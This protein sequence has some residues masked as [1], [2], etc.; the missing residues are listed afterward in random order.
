[1]RLY[2]TTSTV[3]QNDSAILQQYVFILRNMKVMLIMSVIFVIMGIVLGI[4][5]LKHN[6]AAGALCF[7]LFAL[8]A[9]IMFPIGKL[10]AKRTAANMYPRG[11]GEWSVT[12]WLEN[13][14]IHRADDEGEDDVSPLN[15]II[16]GYRAGNVLLLGTNTHSVLPVNLEQLSETD[17][18]S[19]F[20]RLKTECPKL[21]MIQTK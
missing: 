12:T 6:V 16:C 13:D 11:D 15:K 10:S 8:V 21:K 1:M 19:L 9:A 20:D 3:R 18:K 2:E 17:R 5:S 14:G 4:A 7:G